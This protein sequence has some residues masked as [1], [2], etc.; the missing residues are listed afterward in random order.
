MEDYY[1]SLSF[2]QKSI[3]QQGISHSCGVLISNK[4]FFLSVMEISLLSFILKSDTS[5]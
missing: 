1:N 5:Y 4:H 3:R 2:A